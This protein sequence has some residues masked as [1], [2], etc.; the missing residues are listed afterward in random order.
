MA[1]CG[2]MY[3]IIFMNTG[4]VDQAKLRYCSSNL[5]RCN[6]GILMTG[7][8]NC[9]V[10]KDSYGMMNIPSFMTI[11]LGIQ[12]ILWLLPQKFERLQCWY[13]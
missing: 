3:I 9:T 11:G 4:T 2:V 6:V 5:R 13:Y 1:S 7:F 8:L 12:I 10:E